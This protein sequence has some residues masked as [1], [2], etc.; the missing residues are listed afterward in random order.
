MKTNM[1]TIAN[2]CNRDLGRNV[3]NIFLDTFILGVNLEEIKQEIK[4]FT[5]WLPLKKSR[6]GNK[7]LRHWMSIQGNVLVR[8]NSTLSCARLRT[9]IMTMWTIFKVTTLSWQYF[10]APE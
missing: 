9:S 5:S 2:T 3:R 6:Y 7:L 8:N 4:Q 1:A 10:F